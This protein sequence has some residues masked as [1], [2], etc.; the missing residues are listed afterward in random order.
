[1]DLDAQITPVESDNQNYRSFLERESLVS[2]EKREAMP[3]EL[4]AELQGLEQEE[5]RLVQEL[6]Q[7]HARTAAE[8]RAA[9]AENT[10]LNQQK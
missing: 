10:E 6:D 8:L 7:H 3:M 4:C 5:S 2:E 1:M 9:Q